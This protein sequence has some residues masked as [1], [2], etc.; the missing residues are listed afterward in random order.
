MSELKISGTGSLTSGFVHHPGS[1]KHCGFGGRQLRGNRAAPRTQAHWERSGPP[2]P[3]NVE[4]R[5]PRGCARVPALL[6]PENPEASSL[7]EFLSPLQTTHHPPFHLLR[8]S[9]QNSWLIP[10]TAVTF[11]SHFIPPK[12]GPEKQSDLL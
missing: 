5:G 12:K 6:T 1:G 10:V 2:L 7:A 9:Q 8:F 11:L 3:W 4:S